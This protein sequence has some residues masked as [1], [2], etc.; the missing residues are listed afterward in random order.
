[1]AEQHSSRRDHLW[2]PDEEVIKVGNKPTG[3][4]KPRNVIPSE[5]GGKLSTG[6]QSIVDY[7]EH[8]KASD[9][10]SEEDVII[11][12]VTLPEGEKL[13]NSQRMK[14]LA[15][16]GINVNVVKDNRKA[17]VSTSKQR[18]QR[19]RNRVEDYKDRGTFKDFQYLDSF[20]PYTGS[21]KQAGK[22][23]EL[24]L[25]ISPPSTID[26]QLLL[27]PGLGR[28]VYDRILPK[29][30]LRISEAHG[31]IVEKPYFLS[32]GTPVIRTLIPSAVLQGL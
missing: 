15:D 16:N 20:E 25:N 4:D 26:I 28:G 18:F 30:E 6:L 19:L 2:I 31:E 13:D 7:I 11:F 22:L 3:R 12:K 32:D 5:H 14:I 24:A 27:V 1:M 17:I 29:L 8:S 9:T 21:E 10:L 23:R